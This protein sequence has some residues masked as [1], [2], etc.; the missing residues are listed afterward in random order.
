MCE[1]KY[2]KGIL[3]ALLGGEIDHHAASDM[4]ITIDGQ[5][6][7]YKPGTLELDFSKVDFMDSSGVGLVMGR[8]RNMQMLG[9]KLRVINGPDR[10]LKMFRLSGLAHLGIFN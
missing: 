7:R 6:Q 3:T 5:T 1:M 8:Y 10:I 9:G 4:R 2:D